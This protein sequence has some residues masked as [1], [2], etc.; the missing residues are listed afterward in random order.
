MSIMNKLT[1]LAKSDKG[2]ELIDKAQAIAND[3]KTREKI[4]TARGKVEAQ[5]DAAKHK[6]AEK[7]GEKDDTAPTA[8]SGS[9]SATDPMT[10][11]VPPAPATSPP[12]EANYGGDEGPKAA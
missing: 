8:E 3:P 9:A 11:P 12:T 5:V 4:E 1:Q 6:L 2:K 10:T 7:R